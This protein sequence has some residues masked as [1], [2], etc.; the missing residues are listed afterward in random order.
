[1]PFPG[2][3]TIVLA[4]VAATAIASCVA[5]IAVQLWQTSRALTEVD[6]ALSELPP[7]LAGM[8]P[9]VDAINASL[10][11]MAEAAAVP[12]RVA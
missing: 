1:M 3:V 12:Q 11:R 8:E 7:A 5:V 6:Q 10:A 9:A 2:V 4:M